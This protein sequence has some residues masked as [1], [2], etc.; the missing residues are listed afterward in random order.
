MSL[1]INNRN[2]IC[3]LEL[4]CLYNTILIVLVRF[5]STTT[6]KKYCVE[7]ACMAIMAMP[8]LCTL[9]TH[10]KQ[11]NHSFFTLTSRASLV[12]A[13]VNISKAV[14]VLRDDVAA[15]Y[16]RQQSLVVLIMQKKSEPSNDLKSHC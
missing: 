1:I 14:S 3:F 5:E 8:S 16:G 10:D 6:R 9:P 2:F 7:E 4:C 12:N 13:I 11:L 15:D